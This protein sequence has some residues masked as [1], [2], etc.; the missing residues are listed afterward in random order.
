MSRGDASEEGQASSGEDRARRSLLDRLMAVG[1]ALGALIVMF[2]F[3][4][5]LAAVGM[6]YL[7]GRPLL[8]VDELSGYLV[9]T[10][11]MLGVGGTLLKGRHIGIDIFT[12]AAR[13]RIRRGFDVLSALAVLLFALLFGWSAWHTVA[14]NRGFG[15]YSNGPLEIEIWIAQAPM[16]LGAVLLA[17]AA[18]LNLLRAWTRAP[19]EEA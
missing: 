3:A 9:V 4:A 14:F 5:V 17:L 16:V 13:P 7:V 11:T 19:K 8:G 6:R 15:T 18:C 10:L 1:T 2:A 12:N